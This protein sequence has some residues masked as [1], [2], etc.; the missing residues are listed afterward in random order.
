MTTLPTC[1]T[2]TP[3]PAAFRKQ[4]AGIAAAL[5]LPF[6]EKKVIGKK[7]WRW[8]PKQWTFGTLR[9][10]EAGCD[11]LQ[12]PWPDIIISSSQYAIPYALAIRKANQGYTTLIH[13]QKPP[14][15]FTQFDAVIAPLHD[16]AQGD[17]VIHTLGATHDVNEQTLATA[18]NEFLA[19]FKPFRAPYFSI[20]I[21]GS[22]KNYTLTHE[23]MA[24]L[25]NTILEIAKHYPGT[26]LISGSRRT[27]A[28]NMTYLE[29]RCKEVRNIYLYN[30][31][32]KNPYMGMLALADK[33]MITDDSVSMISEACFTGKPVYLLRLPGQ[34]QRRKITEFINEAIKRNH[35][36]Y[37]EGTLE[38][39]DVQRLAETQRI[40][41]DLKQLL[42]DKITL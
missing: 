41:P 4:T 37:Y 25:A 30:N 11:R 18:R 26:L 23:Y 34:Q 17:N 13:I 27:G 6:I 15:A 40:I 2:L 29:R 31:V 19:R 9:Q 20:F 39:W 32:G 22:S 35:I 12:P 24:Q 16:H 7:P 14:I 33:I 3:G 36:R 1:W 5:G 21:G 10:L 28:E 38:T 8:L 42:G